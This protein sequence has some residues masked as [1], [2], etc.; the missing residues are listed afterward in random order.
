MNK[1]T[2]LVSLRN[3]ITGKTKIVRMPGGLHESEA[4]RGACL[5]AGP[6]WRITKTTKENHQ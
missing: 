3:S 4:A 6:N 1:A 5:K 2:W